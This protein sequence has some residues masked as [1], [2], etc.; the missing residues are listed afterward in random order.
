MCGLTGLLEA[1][2]SAGPA[3][4]EAAVRGMAGTLEHRGPD[5][6]GTWVDGDAGVALGFRRLAIVDLSPEGHQPMRSASGRYVI[7]FNGEVYNFGALRAELEREGRAPQFRGHS[8]TEVMLAAIEA[9]GLQAAVSRFVGMF[10]FALWDRHERRLHLVRDRLGIKPMYYGWSGD[11]FLFGSELKALR[12]HPRFRDDLDRDA[13]ALFMRH[14]Y[15]PAPH[16]IYRSVRKLPPGT[17]LSLAA[18]VRAEPEPVAWWSV[19]DAARTG[20]AHPFAGSDDDAVE[21]L[22]AL[23]AEAVSLRMLA[24]VPLGA[25]LSGGIDSSTVVALMQAQ[26]ARPVRT[27]AIGFAEAG[28]N[29]APHAAAVAKHLGTEHTELVVSPADAL[30]VIPRLPSMYDEPFADSSQIPTYLVSALARRSVT[31]SLS[32]DGGDELFGGYSRYPETQELWRRASRLPAGARR[33]AA[34]LME[35]T[36][37]ALAEAVLGPSGFAPRRFRR[38]SPQYTLTRG[39]EVLRASSAHELY[40]LLMSHWRAP[41]SLVLG[42]SEPSPFW[43]SPA[44]APSFRDLTEWMMY[45]D[46]RTY[47]PDD[48]LVKVDRASMAASLE[49]RV[50]LLDHR[51]VE[52]AWTLGAR[53]RQREGQGKWIL[54]QVLERYVPRAMFDRPKMGF[55]VPIAAWL[56]G[57]L[58]DWADTLLD[59][60]RLAAEGYLAP[61]PLR[62]MWEEHRAGRADR[63]S[64][65]W[66]PLMFQAWLEEQRRA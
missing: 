58:R 56:R 49:A 17:M 62:A 4:L 66:G 19:G 31:V 60:A 9:W 41:D 37:A 5:D 36:P 13:L 38:S 3:A 15:I 7:V 59:P 32:G 12:A 51:V 48:I 29:E 21:R 50:P 24:D 28:Y 54:R 16:S 26:S 30:G 33:G 18:H 23:L 64:Y 46:Q 52:F 65:L 45:V 40:H 8:D 25:F 42:A 55:G 11:S 47:L 39:A 22:H 35:R 34:A 6:A 53:F 61:G 44:G 27:F 2:A 1:G 20:L 57:P 14:G 43:R 63:V 10:A